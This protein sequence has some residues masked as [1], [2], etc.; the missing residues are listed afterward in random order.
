MPSA[1]TV[2]SP[3]PTR[4]YWNFDQSHGI[5][6]AMLVLAILA[7]I[8]VLLAFAVESP[9]FDR[10]W[11]LA[12]MTLGGL[13]LFLPIDFIGESHVPHLKVGGW[14][15]GAAF[16]L[17]AIAGALLPLSAAVREAQTWVAEPESGL[18]PE[19]VEQGDAVHEEQHGDDHG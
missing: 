11:L 17:F 18:L 2:P 7:A 13:L 15:G 8:G 19:V 1:W 14:L 10:L 3:A 16:V 9:V 5:G 6:I 4:S 12:G